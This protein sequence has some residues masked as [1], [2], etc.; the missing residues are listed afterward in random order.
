[1]LEIKIPGRPQP[2]QIQAVAL[3]YNG[4]IAR[5]GALLEAA[6][7]CIRQLGKLVPVY[8]LTADT[9]GT[10]QEQCRDLPVC[11]KTFPR[12]NAAP[13][14]EEIVRSLGKGGGKR[15]QR[16]SHV[17]RIGA[18]HRCDRERGRVR[19]AFV[20]RGCGGNLPGGCASSPSEARPPACN[21]AQLSRAA[22]ERN[23]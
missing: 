19:G 5:D 1:M 17:R 18:G 22:A 13:C 4:T 2:L 16:H 7:P 14:K 10:V 23:L 3:D 15:L 11:V 12:E 21:P 8:V 9:Y 6:I 20:P